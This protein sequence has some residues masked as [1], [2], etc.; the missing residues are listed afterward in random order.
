MLRVEK[1]FIEIGNSEAAEKLF[2]DDDESLKKQSYYY[3]NLCGYSIPTIK[4]YKNYLDR[5]TAEKN[6]NIFEN[7]KKNDNEFAEDDL[8]WLNDL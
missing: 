1:E 2:W 5:T 3:N 7:N 6:G 8:S 4:P